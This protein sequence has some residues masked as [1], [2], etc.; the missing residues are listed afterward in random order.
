M[1]RRFIEANIDEVSRKREEALQSYGSLETEP[2]IRICALRN[3]L[4]MRA[5]AEP[6]TFYSFS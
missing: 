5:A 4:G 3:P 6:L 1:E 2:G